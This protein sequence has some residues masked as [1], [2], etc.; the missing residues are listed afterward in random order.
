MTGMTFAKMKRNNTQSFNQ[1]RWVNPFLDHPEHHHLFSFE[2]LC[3]KHTRG[4]AANTRQ[5]SARVQAFLEITSIGH[6]K[7]NIFFVFFGIVG[8]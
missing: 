7:L 6:G 8:S 2:W 5:S 4:S 3:K 1:I